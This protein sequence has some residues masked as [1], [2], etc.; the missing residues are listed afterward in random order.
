MSSAHEIRQKFE[1]SEFFKKIATSDFGQNIAGHS[2]SFYGINS[3]QDKIICQGIS[4]LS[5]LCSSWVSYMYLYVYFPQLV[6]FIVID[7]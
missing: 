3:K 2:G 7:V 5:E 1:K 4:K 6:V